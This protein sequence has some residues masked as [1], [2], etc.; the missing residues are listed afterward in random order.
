MTRAPCSNSVIAVGSSRRVRIKQ[1]VD[2]FT[3]YGN[4][5]KIF[6]IVLYL[7]GGVPVLILPR[8][9]CA[10]A[11]LVPNENPSTDTYDYTRRV[12]CICRK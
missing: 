3:P 5:F 2:V 1:H 8:E 10:A 6:A 12:D 11:I 7:I 9:S 4:I